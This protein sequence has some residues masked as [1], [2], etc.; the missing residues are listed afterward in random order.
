MNFWAG[1]GGQTLYRTLA[2]R[3]TLLNG[4][5]ARAPISL[6]W[7]WKT[8]PDSQDHSKYSPNPGKT[9]EPW[10]FVTTAANLF[11]G[12]ESDVCPAPNCLN[13]IGM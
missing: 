9:L 6:P 11:K 5:Y 3:P 8:L 2:I 7:F 12:L 1:A 4:A 13:E 10:F